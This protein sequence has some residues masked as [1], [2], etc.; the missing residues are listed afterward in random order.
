M[1]TDAT[2]GL[3]TE[4]ADQH[5]RLLALRTTIADERRAAVSP[6]VARAL[7]L[8]DSQVFLA[9]TY[10]GHTGELFPDEQAPA[11]AGRP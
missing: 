8:A 2:P 10:L 9:L 6:A 3:G 7:E 4:V 1:T 5:A 11:D